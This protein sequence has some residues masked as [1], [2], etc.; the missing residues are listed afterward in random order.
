MGGSQGG[1]GSQAIQ[2]RSRVLTSVFIYPTGF[3]ARIEGRDSTS[4]FWRVN[5]S[6]FRHSE[7]SQPVVLKLWGHFLLLNKSAARF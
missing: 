3:L 1:R 7:P 5:F 2:V 4:A 6:G